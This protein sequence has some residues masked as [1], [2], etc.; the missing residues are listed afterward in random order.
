MP[1]HEK[2]IDALAFDGKTTGPEA[3]VQVLAAERSKVAGQA[4]ARQND[5]PAPV[6]T[7]AAKDDAPAAKLGKGGV[8]TRDTDV[9]ALDAAARQYMTNNPS[10]SYVD[11]IKAVQGA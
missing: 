6:K 9:V 2:L 5:A 4:A 3:A 7:E 1:G 11:A 10:V 8:L